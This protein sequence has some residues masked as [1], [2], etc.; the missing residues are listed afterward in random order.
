[1]HTARF[2]K[3]QKRLLIVFKHPGISKNLPKTQGNAQL[4]KDGFADFELENNEDIDIIK[5]ELNKIKNR[6]LKTNK[7]KS[8]NISK[9]LF[10][11]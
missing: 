1:M 7:N 6:L 5:F 4:I 3:D 11:Y 2:C 9:N 10:D 8:N